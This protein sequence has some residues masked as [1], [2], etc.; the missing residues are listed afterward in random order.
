MVQILQRFY[1]T[2]KSPSFG[3]GLK[4]LCCQKLNQIKLPF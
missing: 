4:H 1:S 3:F 2:R